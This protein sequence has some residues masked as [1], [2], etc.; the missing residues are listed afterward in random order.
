[1]SDLALRT[2]GLTK[3]YRDFFW[4][5]KAEASL[6]SLDLEIDRGI[7]FGFL[8]P[9]GAGKTTTIRCLVDLIRPTRGNAWV[10]GK[11]CGDVQVRK[12]IGYLPDAPAFDSH[13]TAQQFL[14]L[15]SRLLKLPRR[16]R[17]D[18]VESVLVEV[19][20][21][22]HAKEPLGD[23]SRGMIQRIGIAQALLNDPEL[24]ILD[25]PLV[26][27]DPH[28]RRELLEIV[29]AQKKNGTTVFF[30]SHI[31]SDV[32]KL[33]DSVGILNRGRLQCAGPLEKLLGVAGVYVTVAGDV[34]GAS[35]M[36]MSADGSQKLEDG[37]WRLEFENTEKWEAACAGKVPESA[38]IE[39]RSEGLEAFFFRTI[40]GAE[41]ADGTPGPATGGE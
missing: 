13:L 3:H 31:L 22:E 40:K 29:L 11:P 26:G 4:R 12:R 34:D 1:M 36:V 30:C 7:V 24:L 5:Q 38:R 17:R 32:E 25:E 8:G 15:C 19:G 2:E 27:L 9:N 20:M 14:M 35:Q 33:C 21:T 10:L 28:G 41:S 37:A 39:S 18:K 16:D 23:F 6:D